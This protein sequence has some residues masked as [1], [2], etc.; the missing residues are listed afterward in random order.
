MIIEANQ[1]DGITSNFIMGVKNFTQEAKHHPKL[2][3]EDTEALVRQTSPGLWE[4]LNEAI[5]SPWTKTEKRLANKRAKVVSIL[6][7]LA[8]SR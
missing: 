3:A 2:T 8:N 7:I 4:T 1:S 5:T 6:N